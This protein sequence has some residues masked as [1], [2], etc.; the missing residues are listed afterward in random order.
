MRL[1][2]QS[3]AVLSFDAGDTLINNLEF[4]DTHV[5]FYDVQRPELVRAHWQPGVPHVSL[6]WTRVQPRTPRRRL[7]I[8]LRSSLYA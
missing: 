6:R 2:R 4:V 8:T 1:S 7:A 3:G 5:H